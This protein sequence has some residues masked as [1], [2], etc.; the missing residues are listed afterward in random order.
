MRYLH[1]AIGFHMAYKRWNAFFRFWM[2]IWFYK[3][4]S[5]IRIPTHIDHCLNS[6]NSNESGGKMW[7]CG[8]K[9]GD[10]STFHSTFSHLICWIRK[11]SRMKIVGKKNVTFESSDW[12]PKNFSSQILCPWPI[13]L[14]ISLFVYVFQHVDVAWCWDSSSF[15]KPIQSLRFVS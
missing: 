6:S 10:I 11:S 13:L 2:K 14:Q 12:F 3:V 7:F 9:K 5:C 15:P 4:I 8:E 1:C